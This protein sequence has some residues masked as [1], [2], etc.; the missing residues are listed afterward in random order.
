M[1]VGLYIIVDDDFER[2]LYGDPDPEELDPDLWSVAVEAIQEAL[3]DEGPTQGITTTSTHHVAWK[4]HTKMGLSFVAVVTDEV[5][6]ADVKTYLKQV[7]KAYFD[8]V[9]DAR[10]PDREGVEDVIIDVVAP[11]EDD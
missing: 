2:P 7:H 1:L 4:M 3:D 11:W 5:T 9:D 10:D 6:P 8:E